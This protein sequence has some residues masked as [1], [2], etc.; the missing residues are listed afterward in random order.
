MRNS[1][2]PRRRRTI[3][4]VAALLAGVV[5]LGA[6][7]AA[8]V[9]AP[10]PVD[11]GTA[12]PYAV[13]A[14]HGISDT[15]PSRIAG[16]V[17]TH[18]L[19]AIPDILDREASGSVDRAGSRPRQAQL[20]LGRAFD[21]VASLARDG[22]ISLAEDRTLLP[23]VYTVD[24]ATEG[25]AGTLTL[26]GQDETNPVWV[27]LVANDLVIAPESWITLVNGAQ[28]CNIFWRIGGSATLAPRSVFVGSIL[29]GT[30]VTVGGGATITGRL[31][32]R[33]GA[34]TLGGA[35]ISVPVCAAG[36]AANRPPATDA[37]AIAA[38]ARIE[39]SPKPE[40]GGVA[41]RRSEPSSLVPIVMAVLLVMA[42]VLGEPRDRRSPR[43]SGGR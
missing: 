1:M 40:V 43:R 39:S 16:D 24:D 15:G 14:G 37:P 13:L 25:F 20:D 29:A 36:A 41:T 26:D 33:T 17:G 22:T 31:L 7:P 34:V 6:G 27:F 4:G 38:G 19:P 42:V 8:L 12:A 28:A 5:L 18:P 21:S 32:A 11:L 2:P 3:A 35:S 30:S 10:A 9:P 23:G